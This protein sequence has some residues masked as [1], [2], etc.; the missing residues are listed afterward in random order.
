MA[1]GIGAS[2]HGPA[3]LAFPGMPLGS[4]RPS[5]PLRS[6][7]SPGRPGA[8]P[9]S[10]RLTHPRRRP[11]GVPRHSAQAQHGTFGGPWIATACVVQYLLL[12][13]APERGATPAPR[14]PPQ[15]R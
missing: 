11:A 9:R 1:C 3:P 7:A 8:G 13:P 2:R 10:P 5:R 6:A 14:K 15:C 12:P 4:L